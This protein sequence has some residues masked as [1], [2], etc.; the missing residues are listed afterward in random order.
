MSTEKHGLF[1][2]VTGTLTY[3]TKFFKKQQGK[4]EEYLLHTDE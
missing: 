4:W 3:F 2:F 1:S